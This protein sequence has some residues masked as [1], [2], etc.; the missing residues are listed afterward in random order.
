MFATRLLC[1]ADL[2]VQIGPLIF[3]GLRRR[4]YL[5]RR[6]LSRRRLGLAL[7]HLFQRRHDGGLQRFRRDRLDHHGRARHRGVGHNGKIGA[8][9]PWVFGDDKNARRLR[10]TRA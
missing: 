7:L 4:S 3:S 10:I 6:L 2:F 9:M 8:P 5:A 1:D